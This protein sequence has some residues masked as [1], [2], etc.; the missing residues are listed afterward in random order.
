[1]EDGNTCIYQISPP[2][3]IIVKTQTQ[4]LIRIEEKIKTLYPTVDL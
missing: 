4:N 1:M 2:L 3:L